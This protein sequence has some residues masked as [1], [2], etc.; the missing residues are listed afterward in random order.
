[1]DLGRGRAGGPGHRRSPARAGTARAGAA[2]AGAARAGAVRA[3]VSRACGLRAGAARAGACAAA[4]SLAAALLAAAPGAAGTAAASTAAAGGTPGGPAAAKICAEPS[5]GGVLTTGS[6]RTP[7]GA[8]AA[9]VRVDQV[10]YPSGAAKLAEIMTRAKPAGRPS[11]GG[12]PGRVLHG[13]CLRGGPPG[14]RRLEQALRLGVGGPVHRGPGARPVPGRDP[15]RRVGGVTL[16]HDRPGR[17]PLRAAAGQRAVFLRE[18]AGRP[19]LHPHRA[20]QRARPP[21]R[22]QRDDLPDP[23]GGQQRQLQGQPGPVRDR[24]GD[25]RDRWLVRRRGLPALRGDDQ[26]HRGR[27]AAGRRVVPPA[28]GLQVRRGL[29]RRGQVRPGLPAADVARALPHA[30]LRGGHGRGEQLLLRGPRHLA[31]APGR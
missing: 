26:L 27:A 12:G 25:Q 30:V 7:A 14:P 19:G 4:F 6:H 11:L 17:S 22:R 3:G 5:S 29:H 23:A 21:Q 15:G 28:D 9:A 13:G 24:D 2:R 1:M 20:A 8:P 16:V 31:A 10:G 18:R